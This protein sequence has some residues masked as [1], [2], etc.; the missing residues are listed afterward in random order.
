MNYEL[1]EGLIELNIKLERVTQNILPDGNKD[2]LSLRDKVLFVLDREGEAPP[3]VLTAE[4]GIIKSNLASIMRT[5]IEQR[6][7]LSKQ[8]ER[9]GRAIKY[10]LTTKGKAELAARIDRAEQSITIKEK[11][12]KQILKLAQTLN[13]LL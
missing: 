6:V 11:K 5:L 13:E 2:S 3:S 4:L 1:S 12:R 10:S 9:D 8:D 7:A